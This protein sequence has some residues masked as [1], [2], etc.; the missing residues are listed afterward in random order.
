[1][2]IFLLRILKALYWTIWI[3]LVSPLFGALGLGRG[4]EEKMHLRYRDKHPLVFG[5]V[6]GSVRIPSCQQVATLEPVNR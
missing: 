2:I 6:W 5:V 1:M 4:S 3:Q